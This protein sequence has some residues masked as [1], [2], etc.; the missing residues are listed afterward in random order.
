M[1][2]CIEAAMLLFCPIISASPQSILAEYDHPFL[3]DSQ[4][5]FR[6]SDLWRTLAYPLVTNN[7]V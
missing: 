7:R 2:S 1:I 3:K 6:D 4:L 5:W